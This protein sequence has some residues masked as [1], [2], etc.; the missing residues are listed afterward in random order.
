[1]AFI[2]LAPLQ[3][4]HPLDVVCVHPGLSDSI[5]KA[6]RGVA[7]PTH[8]PRPSRILRTRMV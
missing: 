4:A 2:E 8:F 7:G 6:V 3:N 5:P 1:M